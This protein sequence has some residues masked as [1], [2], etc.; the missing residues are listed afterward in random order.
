MSV[1]E[2]LETN[3]NPIRQGYVFALLPEKAR[4]IYYDYVKKA[5]DSLGLKCESFLDYKE[6]ED[7]FRAIIEG[8]QKGEIL[9]YDVSDF[10]PNVMWEL[11]VGLAIKDAEKVI[12]IREKS[13]APLPFNIYSHRISFQYD[14]TSE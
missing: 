13:E 8:I 5:A 7:A 10:T 1:K 14:S 12:V 11:G 3:P 9:L 2:F 4:D 6:P